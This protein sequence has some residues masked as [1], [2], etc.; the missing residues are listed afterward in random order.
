MKIPNLARQLGGFFQCGRSLSVVCAALCLIW[1][2]LSFF[3][4]VDFSHLSIPL[5]VTLDRTASSLEI[6]SLKLN[7]ANFRFD[8]LSGVILLNPRSP[9][10]A[11]TKA[12]H[13]AIIPSFLIVCIVSW[14]ICTL[15]RK[16]CVRVEHG[17]IF[18]D[19]NLRYISNVGLVLL[20]SPFCEGAL[21][22]WL[23]IWLNHFLAAEVKITGI[24]A[25]L[26]F[27]NWDWNS[28]I[29]EVVTG[30]LVLLIAEAFRQGLAL[31]KEND[32]TV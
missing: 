6:E 8:R 18:S 1:L 20:I 14:L 22:L 19:T 21:T 27:G 11:V 32:L 3:P 10:P 28:F 16:I 4:K 26:Q 7:G 13:Y 5:E 29:K 30:F 31:K 24:A 9:N 23:R 17:E 12:I 15:L 25:T 2:T